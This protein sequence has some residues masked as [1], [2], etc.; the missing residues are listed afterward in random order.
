MFYREFQSAVSSVIIN[1]NVADMTSS[2]NR[3]KYNAK[4]EV[5]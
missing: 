4:I 5:S 3:K 1:Y 2:L